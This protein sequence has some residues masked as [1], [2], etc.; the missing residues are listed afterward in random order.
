[1]E[2]DAFDTFRRTC[3]S[4][5]EVLY[6]WIECIQRAQTAQF[7]VHGQ[8]KDI[9]NAADDAEREV[10][11]QLHIELKRSP[12]FTGKKRA[13]STGSR[14]P[15]APTSPTSAAS[16]MSTPPQEPIDLTSPI[17]SPIPKRLKISHDSS[18]KMTPATTSEPKNNPVPVTNVQDGPHLQ[19]KQ[20]SDKAKLPTRGSAFAAGYDQNASK[21]TKISAR[22]KG[23]VDTDLSMAVPAGTCKC[24]RLLPYLT[25]P[26]KNA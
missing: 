15:S 21:E 12:R 14:L 4:E 1:M 5:S 2:W 20:P 9:F 26:F 24:L 6:F 17:T 10:A 19:T 3:L 11:L 8:S 25:M 23:L 16:T 13:A 22:G 7:A 18:D